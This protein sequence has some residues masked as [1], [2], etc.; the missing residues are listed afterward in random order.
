M[1]ILLWSIVWLSG[2]VGFFYL[3]HYL[4]IACG[5][6]LIKAN[7]LSTIATVSIFHLMRGFLKKAL[8]N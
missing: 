1:K 7:I 3:S 6:T 2:L 5:A 8:S 4:A